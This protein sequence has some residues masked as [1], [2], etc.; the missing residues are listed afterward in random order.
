[1]QTRNKEMPREGEFS[2]SQGIPRN[3]H[4]Q[5]MKKKG[6]A[7]E[8]L[9]RRYPQSGHFFPKL[10]HFLLISKIEQGRSPPLPPLVTQLIQS[11]VPKVKNS[12]TSLDDFKTKLR[13]WKLDYP[14]L[15]CKLY[16]QNIAFIQTFF[17]CYLIRFDAIIPLRFMFFVFQGIIWKPV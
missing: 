6:S 5:N 4:L 17:F 12:S 16:L 8:N 15:S 14:C 10:G 11:L 1:M 7:G 13:Q 9:T 2:S 3:N